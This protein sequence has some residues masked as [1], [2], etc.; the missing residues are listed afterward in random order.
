MT[1]AAF[2]T[3]VEDLFRLNR[4]LVY[5]TRDSRGS[6]AGFP[7]LVAAHTR[8]GIVFAELKSKRGKV[9]DDQEAWLRILDRAKPVP[10]WGH[11]RVS[12][13]TWRPDDWPQ[14]EEV[15]SGRWS[16]TE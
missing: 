10:H 2:Q 6:A 5:H 12:V 14:I 13:F 8:H 15:A 16:G 9:S 11:Q 4:W 1:E 3:M 7:D